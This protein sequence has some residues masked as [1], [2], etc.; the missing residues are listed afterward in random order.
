MPGYG[1]K[2]YVAVIDSGKDKPFNLVVTTRGG[3]DVVDEASVEGVSPA[4]ML[5][6]VLNAFWRRGERV[7]TVQ[8]EFDK[9]TSLQRFLIIT[10]APPSKEN[11]GRDL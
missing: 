9:N 7:V 10:E 8:S 1:Y 11:W 6:E 4:E 3:R 5:E 2:V